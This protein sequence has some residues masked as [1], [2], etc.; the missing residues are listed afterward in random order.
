MA[1]RRRGGQ[2]PWRGREDGERQVSRTESRDLESDGLTEKVDTVQ[3]T[4]ESAR[5]SL[6]SGGTRTKVKILFLHITPANMHLSIV[7]QP[8]HPTLCTQMTRST[9]IFEWFPF[10]HVL[11][12]LNSLYSKFLSDRAFFF[13]WP[14]TQQVIRGYSAY[15]M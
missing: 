3:S 10:F 9:A 11:G 12:L 14:L 5:F 8:P 7:P 2:R 13:L 6:A 1:R 15:R 4:T